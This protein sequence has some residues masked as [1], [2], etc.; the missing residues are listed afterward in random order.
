VIVSIASFTRPWA[1]AQT[2]AIP[3]IAILEAKLCGVGL[4]SPHGHIVLPA[5][6]PTSATADRWTWLLGEKA[7]RRWLRHTTAEHTR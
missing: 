2:A 1:Q 7:Y 6:P 3:D 4:L 5:E